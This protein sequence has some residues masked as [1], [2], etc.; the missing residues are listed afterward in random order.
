M[1]ATQERVVFR[2]EIDENGDLRSRYTDEIDL[3]SLGTVTNV[4]RASHI[5][6]DEQGQE[7]MVI[8]AVTDQVVHRNKR[9][10][11]A[12]AWEQEHFGPGGS[13]DGGDSR[14]RTR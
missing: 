3:Y 7:F 8:D 5:K 6:F 13:H 10:C 14:D 9:R 12:I 1:T 11:D 2:F 4:R